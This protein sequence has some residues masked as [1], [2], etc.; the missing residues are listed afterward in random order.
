MAFI[1]RRR[2]TTIVKLVALILAIWFCVIFLIYTDDTRR[3]AAQE[4]SGY[5]AAVPAVGS[6]NPI[7]LA[8]KN[9]PDSAEDEFDADA[10]VAAAEAL[11]AGPAAGAAAAAAGEAG[12][13]A[14]VPPTAKQHK[15]AR[16]KVLPRA[17][18]AEDSWR[19]NAIPQSED[20]IVHKPA[21]KEDGECSYAT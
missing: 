13:E 10:A 3:R 1:W 8:L 21:A 7:A 6:G 12:Q 2:S 11:A 19:Q 17:K 4:T 20:K 15:V 16:V 14:D 18:V 5:G 9:G